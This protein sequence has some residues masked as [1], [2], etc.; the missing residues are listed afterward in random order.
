LAQ[1]NHSITE[2]INNLFKMQRASQLFYVQIGAF[3]NRRYAHVIKRSFEKKNYPMIVKKRRIGI[4]NYYKLLIG[5][6]RS[7]QEAYSIKR[8][9]PKAYRD[10]FVL[11]EDN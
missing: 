8:L 1:E 4:D 2:R 10:A 11:T 7:R 3:K 5:P 6:L 9:L